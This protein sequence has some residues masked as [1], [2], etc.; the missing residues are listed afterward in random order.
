MPARDIYHE[1]VKNAPIKDGWTIT[2]DPFLLRWGGKDTYVDLGAERIIAAEKPGEQIAVEVK[3]FIHK[4]EMTDLER[5]V[6]Q[7]VVHH[8]M[9]EEVEPERLLYL[10]VHQKV[11]KSIF[12]EPIG[13]MAIRKQ[14][15]RLIDFDPDEE[16]IEKWI[17]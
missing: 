9:L 1:Q 14:H 10:A 4:S 8:N 3:S 5:A 11:Y 12:L 16:V 13:E 2:H 15:L 17:P 6:G 7:Y